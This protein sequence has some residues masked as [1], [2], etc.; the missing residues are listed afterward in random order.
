MYLYFIFLG[1]FFYSFWNQNFLIKGLEKSGIIIIFCNIICN[2][3]SEDVQLPDFETFYVIIS[4]IIELVAAR[5]CLSQWNMYWV[6]WVNQKWENE[7][8]VYIFS[9]FISLLNSLLSLLSIL[10][11]ISF[12]KSSNKINYACYSLITNFKNFISSY[13]VIIATNMRYVY[14]HI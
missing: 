7:M 12:F 13:H 1:Y 9:S 3:I 14:I 2:R 10:S 8:F 11:T 6:E 5:G 4:I